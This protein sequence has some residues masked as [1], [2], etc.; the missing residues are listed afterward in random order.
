MVVFYFSDKMQAYKL[1]AARNRI[2][3]LLGDK[4]LS[5]PSASGRGRQVSVPHLCCSAVLV[6]SVRSCLMSCSE[7]ISGLVLVE[8]S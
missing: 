4:V 2:S 8:H 1:L 6:S 3:A 7:E 5:L